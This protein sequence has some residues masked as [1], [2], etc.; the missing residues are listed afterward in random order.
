M[1]TFGFL[2]PCMFDQL[3]PLS[4]AD[5]SLYPT[6][7]PWKLSP[8]STQF[9]CNFTAITILVAKPCFV[10]LLCG[11]FVNFAGFSHL[12]NLFKRIGTYILVKIT[13]STIKAPRMIKLFCKL[14]KRRQTIPPK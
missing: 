8:I 14:P 3:R 5:A 6:E 9:Y 7:I 4:A 13:T 10:K 12:Y 2:F 1:N 11:S